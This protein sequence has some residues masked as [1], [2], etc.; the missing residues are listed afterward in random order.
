M[1][2]HTYIHCHLFLWAGASPWGSGG[3]APNRWMSGFFN[4]K[5]ALFGRKAC[6]IQQSNTVL[7]TR[8]V[9][10][11]SNMLKYGPWCCFEGDN[12]KIK[13]VNFFLEKSAPSQLLC[14]L[15]A[16]F[17]LCACLWLCSTFIL[18]YV[19]LCHIPNDSAINIVWV[20]TTVI[21]D[22]AIFN[23]VKVPFYT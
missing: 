15:N 9:L 2:I 21:C 12:Q 18:S 7:S 5:M 4:E 1:N 16:K 17:W 20:I 3:H 11:A 23:S 8:S 19:E 22:D 10:W 14:P 6:F 13:V